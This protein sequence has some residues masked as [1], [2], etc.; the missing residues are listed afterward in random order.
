MHLYIDRVKKRPR[1]LLEHKKV[2]R[3]IF[4]P[5]SRE[6]TFQMVGPLDT[7]TFYFLTQMELNKCMIWIREGPSRM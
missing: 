1:I 3:K 7:Q 5:F 6:D 4:T 2:Q